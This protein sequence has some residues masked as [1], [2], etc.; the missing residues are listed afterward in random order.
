V[1]LLQLL[2]VSSLAAVW[3]GA[4]LAKQGAPKLSL[5]AFWACNPHIWFLDAETV[6]IE[7]AGVS[8]SP[9][10]LQLQAQLRQWDDTPLQVLLL[11][12]RLY[13]AVHAPAGNADIVSCNNAVEFTLLQKHVG[14]RSSCC[15]LQIY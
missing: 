12:L 5:N 3:P 13:G 2:G 6:P 15:C 4:L 10:L 14:S 11:P 7:L 8:S 9:A 1:L